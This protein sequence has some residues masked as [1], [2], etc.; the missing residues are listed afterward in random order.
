MILPKIYNGRNKTFF[1]G[2]YQG[3]RIHQG[4][5]KVFTV[6]TAAM[7]AGNF[8]GFGTIYD[9]A[10]TQ[11]APSGT[12][13]RTPFPNNQIPSNRFDPIMQKF[14]AFYPLPNS[15]P[16]QFA[17]NN[18]IF[19]PKFLNIADQG[20]TRLDHRFSDKDSFFWSFSISDNT[21][22]APMNLPGIPFGGYFND[23]QLRPQV[24]R[25][26]HMGLAETHVFSPR[27]VNEVPGRIQPSLLYRLSS[28]EWCQPWERSTAYREFRPSV[29]SAAFRLSVQR[30]LRAS[31][32]P[33]PVIG[34]RT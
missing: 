18:F 7:Q 16:A 2:D 20:D 5:T 25:G 11:P 24:F 21:Q 26:Q 19:N 3:T 12:Y 15:G 31:V 32:R 10:T 28:V 34:A 22:I 17:A 27:L 33:L 30:G 14:A 1:F 9:P 4:L 8:S 29:A 6:P 13:V 23:L